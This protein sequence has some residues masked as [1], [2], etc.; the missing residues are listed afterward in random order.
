MARTVWE[1]VVN[2]DGIISDWPKLPH[3]TRAILESKVDMLR[4]AEVDESGKVT[5]PQ[6]AISG[7]GVFG[8]AGIYKLRVNGS[9]AIR[10]MLCLGPVDRD[11]EW[12][13]LAR[14]RE[15]N[16]DTSEQKAAAKLARERIPRIVAGT[17][18]RQ[19]LPED[20]P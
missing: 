14:A 4:R 11:L 19:E 3:Q 17:I 7:P 9:W 16:N 10:P 15:Q 5:L 1:A 18:A 20:E 2:G 8:Q 12:T 13:I 6:G